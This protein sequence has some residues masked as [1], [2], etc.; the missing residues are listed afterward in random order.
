MTIRKYITVLCIL[1]SFL[2]TPEAVW[3]ASCGGA[4]LGEA[5]GVKNSTSCKLGIDNLI[6]GTICT[7]QSLMAASMTNVYCDL[8]AEAMDVLGVLLTLYV[9]FYAMAVL[10]KIKEIKEAPFRLL[11]VTV[12]TIFITNFDYF[13]TYIY[14]VAFG[15]LDEISLAFMGL[16]DSLVKVCG[17]CPAAGERMLVFERVDVIFNSVV[18]GSTVA[19]LA[20]LSTAWMA[21]GFGIPVALLMITGMVGMLTSFTRLMISY[22]TSIMALTFVLMFTPMF[23]C[24]LFFEQTKQL[25]NRWVGSIVSYTLQPTLVLAFLFVLGEATSIDTLLRGVVCP[26][27]YGSSVL[28]VSGSGGA[29]SGSCENPMIERAANYKIGFRWWYEI[30]VVGPRIK[31]AFLENGKGGVLFDKMLAFLVA[32]YILN[33]V[34]GA[35]LTKIPQLSQKLSRFVGYRGAPTLASKSQT[36]RNIASNHDS[37]IESGGVDMFNIGGYGAKYGDA[38][39][40]KFTSKKK[41]GKDGRVKRGS[42]G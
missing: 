32:F 30:S 40:K 21:T 37:N 34:T 11:K 35:F 5:F 36:F 8:V 4:D 39:A 18:G 3:A 9:I 24:F 26:G 10:F 42:P 14:Q 15:F 28:G 29:A 25:F 22:L 38:L 17:N 13:Y 16:D 33:V 20:V 41:G 12:I 7:V 27:T 31:D 19:G 1:L 2:I 6:S 23:F